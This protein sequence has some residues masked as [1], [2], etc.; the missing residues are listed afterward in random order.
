MRCQLPAVLTPVFSRCS[1]Q[2]SRLP[3]L[4]SHPASRPLASTPLQSL[5][6]TLELLPPSLLPLAGAGENV[7]LSFGGISTLEYMRRTLPRRFVV[8][9]THAA[10]LGYAE[11]ELAENVATWSVAALAR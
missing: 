4:D 11:A 2:A 3:V 8:L 7:S 9:G 6:P 10:V 1:A 5:L